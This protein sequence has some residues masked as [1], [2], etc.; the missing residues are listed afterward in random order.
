MQA[1][2]RAAPLRSIRRPLRRRRGAAVFNS[3]GHGPPRAVPLETSA[4]IRG[5]A[6]RPR[7]TPSTPHVFFVGFETVQAKQLANL[8]LIALLAMMFLLI[9]D[10]TLQCS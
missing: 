10:V 6:E 5:A 1:S 7:R 3:Q 8:V 4:M 9:R 2:L